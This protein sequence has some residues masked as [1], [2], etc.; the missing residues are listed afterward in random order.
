MWKAWRRRQHLAKATPGDGSA[1]KPH[2]P[3]H[4]PTRS[5][6]RIALPDEDGVEHEYSVD[7]DYFDWN[8]TIRFYR[9]GREQLVAEA[10]AAFPVP[11]GVVEVA[12]GTFGVTRMHLVSDTG[13]EE[14]V[15]RPVRHSQEY[16]RAV[17]DHRHPRLS[18]WIGR[19]AIAVL[20]VGLVIFV[21]QLLERATEWDLVAERVGTF[22][23]PLA[24]P[25]WLNT[26]LFVAGIAASLERALSLRNHW[27]IDIDTWWLG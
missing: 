1:L 3:W 21:P 23:S 27:L 26:T 14:R 8:D 25:G 11:G 5:V 17:L 24:L 15:L 20:L 19:V 12:T 2:R 7:V 6:F 18:R 4:I 16:W 9:D 13:G 10:P 22:T